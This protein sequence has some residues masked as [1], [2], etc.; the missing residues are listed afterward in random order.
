MILGLCAVLGRGDLNEDE[1]MGGGCTG[2]AVPDPLSDCI[3]PVH[4]LADVQRRGN[5]LL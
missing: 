4:H 2:A 5:D 3:W 1:K